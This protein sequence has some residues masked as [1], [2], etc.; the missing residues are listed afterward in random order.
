M[1]NLGLFKAMEREGIDVVKTP[2]GDKYVYEGLVARGG[3][4]AASSRGTLSSENFFRRATV[5]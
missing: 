1:A 4:L 2:V 3:M 5:Y